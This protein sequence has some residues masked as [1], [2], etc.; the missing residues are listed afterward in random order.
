MSLRLG[1]DVGGTNTDAVVLNERAELLA[2]FKSPTT[3]DVT[4]GIRN[5]L[6]GLVKTHPS[7][8]LGAIKYADLSGDR[9]S[10]YVFDWDRMLAATGNTGPYLQYACARIRSIFV[11]SAFDLGPVALTEPAAALTRRPSS[12]AAPCGPAGGRAG[13]RPGA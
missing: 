4:G 7:L 12:H 8:D 9:R 6:D 3:P 11:R 13:G 10:D 2:S 1:I 5:A